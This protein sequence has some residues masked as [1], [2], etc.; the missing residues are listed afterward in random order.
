MLDKYI[1][2]GTLS[3]GR[4]ANDIKRRII[5]RPDIERMI[6][7]PAIKA[8][9]IGDVYNDKKP[10]SQWDKEHLEIVSLDALAK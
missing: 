9:F 6:E 7:D 3:H 8:S 10:E 2:D 1:V 4:I 5:K